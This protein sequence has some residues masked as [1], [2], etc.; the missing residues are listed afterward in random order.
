MT[1][2]QSIDNVDIFA[3][4]SHIRT[5]FPGAIQIEL[6]LTAGSIL[7]EIQLTYANEKSAIETAEHVTSENFKTTVRII[8]SYNV[9]SVTNP[10]LA[11]EELTCEQ[12]HTM[13]NSQDCCGATKSNGCN[14]YLRVYESSCE[15]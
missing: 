14:F 9:K 2:D 5:L 11:T 10:T 3:L 15:C 8:T 4:E 7:V 1:L 6:K 13:Y 12:I